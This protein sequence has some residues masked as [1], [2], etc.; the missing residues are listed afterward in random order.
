MFLF[1]KL[2]FNPRQRLKSTGLDRSKRFKR[3]YLCDPPTIDSPD[4]VFEDPALEVETLLVNC[5]HLVFRKLVEKSHHFLWLY[6]AGR[7]TI[8]FMLWWI[9]FVF[10]ISKIRIVWYSVDQN[11]FFPICLRLHLRS[12][13][14]L[15]YKWLESN[16]TGQALVR[17]CRVLTDSVLHCTLNYCQKEKLNLQ[18]TNNCFRFPSFVNPHWNVFIPNNF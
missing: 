8:N 6:H 5:N 15:W 11:T 13:V 10:N 7:Q 1:R 18:N 3:S 4:L 2:G 16:Q 14:T 17:L 12:S 9:C